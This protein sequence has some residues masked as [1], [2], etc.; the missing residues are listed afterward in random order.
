MYRAGDITAA[1]RTNI[2]LAGWDIVGNRKTVWK[3]RKS[4]APIA[5]SCF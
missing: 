1:M 5:H 2:R 4:F 3:E